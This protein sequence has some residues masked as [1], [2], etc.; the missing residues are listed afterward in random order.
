MEKQEQFSAAPQSFLPS[1]FGPSRGMPG[2]A[3]VISPSP[4]TMP[5][6][7]NQKNTK[8]MFN[9]FDEIDL[10]KDHIPQLDDSDLHKQE[11]Q[12]ND[13]LP[14]IFGNKNQLPQREKA[15]LKKSKKKK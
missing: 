5:S 11:K 3:F 4:D 6:L 7:G 2:A 8:S 15:T 12:K 1:I 9:A 13:G 10:E 14:D